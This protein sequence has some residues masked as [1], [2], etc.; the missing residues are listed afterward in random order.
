MAD[1]VRELHHA[2][3]FLISAD[4]KKHAR[5]M[6]GRDG[7]PGWQCFGGVDVPGTPPTEGFSN[8]RDAGFSGQNDLVAGWVPGQNP[9]KYPDNAG[10]LMNA[11]DALVLQIHYHH[12]G[13]A[14]PDRSGLTLQLDD[15]ATHPNIKKVRVVNPLAP[16]EIPCAPGSTAKLCDRDAAIRDDVR[17][18][19]SA[20]S[21]IE[22][23][24]LTLCHQTPAK[25]TADFN[26]SVAHS[27]CTLPVPEAGTIFSVLGHMHTLGK[28]INLTVNPGKPDQTVLLDIPVWNFDWQL[29]F[30]LV[31]PVHVKRGDVVKLSC[32]WDRSLDP[33]RDPKYIVFAEGTED[34]MC[35]GTYAMVPDDQSGS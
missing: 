19:G 34:E 14:T 26:G 20:G 22:A 5:K 25:L 27:E 18:Y 31:H 17:L 23:G 10:V 33:N 9:T 3:V 29:N 35:F 4:Q 6:S 12:E 28:S 2:Q 21:Y 30:G 8:R 32:T 11:G 15:A 7:K 16:V 1:Q 24:L 13:K